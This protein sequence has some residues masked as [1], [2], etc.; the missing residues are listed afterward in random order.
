[1]FPYVLT[2]AWTTQGRLPCLAYLSCHIQRSEVYWHLLDQTLT[3]ICIIRVAPD[4]W[5]IIRK[6]IEI[7]ANFDWECIVN[8][9]FHLPSVFM[10]THLVEWWSSPS[11]GVRLFEEKTHCDSTKYR[12][13][14]K[15]HSLMWLIITLCRSALL[16]LGAAWPNNR[17]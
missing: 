11:L 14:R 5:Y 13:W 3:V 1:M 9:S 8:I 6:F 16:H 12:N 15:K 10:F 4:L 17:N 7:Q 2:I